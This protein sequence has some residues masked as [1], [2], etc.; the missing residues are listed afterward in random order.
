METPRRL[1]P[2]PPPDP[3]CLLTKTSASLHMALRDTKHP[4]C[5]GSV[6]QSS[7]NGAD[8]STS[9]HSHLRELKSHLAPDSPSQGCLDLPVAFG[10]GWVSVPHSMRRGKTERVRERRKQE[11]PQ[12]HSP[13]RC[14]PPMCR[15]PTSGPPSLTLISSSP[16]GTARAPGPSGLWNI[17]RILSG[18][19][20]GYPA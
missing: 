12:L 14:L 3:F 5:S 13:P 4:L 10:A 9:S 2:G 19:Q 15:S 11:G 17:S 1:W 16:P 7:S 8:L 20:G 18:A 6:S